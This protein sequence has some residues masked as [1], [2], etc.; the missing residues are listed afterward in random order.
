M[1]KAIDYKRQR[2]RF[3]L[4]NVQILRSANLQEDRFA[5]AEHTRFHGVK[6]SN[7]NSAVQYEVSL[8]MLWITCSK[9][10]S[11]VSMRMNSG[12]AYIECEMLRNGQ[13]H[14]ARN[15]IRVFT[16]RNV[17]IWVMPSYK[18]LISYFIVITFSDCEM[19]R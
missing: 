16:L 3:L 1:G 14:P 6:C 9:M 15:W 17:Q 4:Q 5:D 7:M 12:M 11:T 8:L 18:G 2:N 10:W 19:F 13:Y